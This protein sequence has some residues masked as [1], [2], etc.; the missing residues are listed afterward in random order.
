[1]TN[2]DV[3]RKKNLHMYLASISFEYFEGYVNLS[4]A[5][6]GEHLLW[7]QRFDWDKKTGLDPKVLY[8]LHKIIDDIIRNDSIIKV[9]SGINED[10][11]RYVSKNY[12]R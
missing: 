1:M 11:A 3:I 5:F 2:H 9:Q 7:V 6:Q 10:A 4:N 8:P 12:H